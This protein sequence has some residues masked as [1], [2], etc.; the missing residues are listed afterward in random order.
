MEEQSKETEIR[1][2]DMWTILKRCW[3]QMLIVAVLLAVVL[4]IGLTFT[5]EDQYTATSSIFVMATPTDGDQLDTQQISIAANLINDCQELIKSHDQI[6]KPTI[7]S[8]QS[9]L[10]ADELKGMFTVRRAETA[11]VLYLSVTSS[12]AKESAK[13][14][15]ELTE[16]VCEYFNQLFD[17]EL[18]SIVDTA[19]TPKAPSNPI[20]MLTILLVAFLGAFVVYGAQFLR[21]V[22]DDKINSAEDVEKYLGLSMLGVIPNKH[23]S[24]RK[25]SKYGYYYSHNLDGETKKQ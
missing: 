10:T 18:L 20:S 5:H 15:N 21:F 2:Q 24:N 8:L 23:D 25:K 12:D 19:R 7:D 3:W 11:R 16:N 6:L 17:K 1:L 13:I 4:Y 22:L 14:V 9:S